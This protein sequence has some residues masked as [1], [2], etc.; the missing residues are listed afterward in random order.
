[1]RMLELYPRVTGLP[2]RMT[3]N[4]NH[5]LSFFSPEPGVTRVVDI[6]G[7]STDLAIS[8]ENFQSYFGS[9]AVLD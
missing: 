1:M 5:L 8:Y 4:P 2:Y 3:V 7:G 9:V 6:R